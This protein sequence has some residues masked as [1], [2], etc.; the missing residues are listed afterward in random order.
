MLN[1][2]KTKILI[3]TQVLD[4]NHPALGFFL[5]WI[6]EFAKHCEQITVIC[7]Y[8]GEYDLPENVRVLSL[9]KEG[10][11]FQFS[12]FNFQLISKFKYLI[13]FYKFIW[14]ERKNYD[15]VFIHMN[16]IYVILGGWCWRLFGK[17]IGLWYTHGKVSLSLRMAEKITNIIFTA[18]KES[19]RLDSG[20][21]RIVGHGIDLNKFKYWERKPGDVFK[22][23]TVGR[24]SPVKDLETIINAYEILEKK[25]E[26]VSLEFI[27]GAGL[28]EHQEYLNEMRELVKKK[29]LNDKIIFA[30]PVPVEKI[31]EYLYNSDLF[32]SASRT[33]SLDKVVI[34]AMATGL[35]V[36]SS[37]EAFRGVL[38]VFS[39]KL[40]SPS[41]CEGGGQEGVI[42]ALGYKEKNTEE[43]AD[44][45]S[46]IIKH[47]DGELG[48]NLSEMTKKQHG[49]N[50][51]IIKICDNLNGKTG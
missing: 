26:N 37:N 50:N 34:E 27:G 31:P 48:R 40:K 3:F 4:H 51:L 11:N 9:G 32:V 28:P 49:L 29:G 41:P 45:I 2:E 21:I 19:C 1:T 20:K 16:Q 22:I 24:I 10:N 44:K 23:I 17:R 12:I 13:N 33:G 14:R 18:S 42:S 15:K 38:E 5:D 35:P 47:Q 36:I 30:G 43:L 39:N 6:R 7:L 25:T 8:K 46:S